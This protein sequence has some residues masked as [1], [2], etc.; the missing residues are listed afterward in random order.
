[1]VC[2]AVDHGGKEQ[3]KIV[4]IMKGRGSK[5]KEKTGNEQD[6]QQIQKGWRK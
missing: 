4:W 6:E 5:R 2:A 3:N 1:M